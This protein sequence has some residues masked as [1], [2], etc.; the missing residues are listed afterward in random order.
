MSIANPNTALN[1]FGSYTASPARR[2]GDTRSQ[3][4]QYE[5]EFKSRRDSSR[6]RFNL[7]AKDH[8]EAL[9]KAPEHLRYYFG[10]S[11]HH[12]LPPTV[13]VQRRPSREEITNAYRRLLINKLLFPHHHRASLDKAIHAELDHPVIPKGRK[14]NHYTLLMKADDN[15]LELGEFRT[16]H[17]A[18]EVFEEALNS[19]EF[20]NIEFGIGIELDDAS[21]VLAVAADSSSSKGLAAGRRMH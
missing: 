18:L 15:V 4:E 7:I 1:P 3:A 9:E 20:E 21:R 12:Y 6:I 11:P 14:V 13:E 17:S 19:Q 2:H 8:I 16:M 10:E 5:I